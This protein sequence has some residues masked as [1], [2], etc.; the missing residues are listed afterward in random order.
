MSL[1]Q[2]DVK[3]RYFFLQWVLAF[4]T[5]YKLAIAG[6]LVALLMTSTITLSLGQGIRVMIDQGFT[7]SQSDLNQAV[8]IFLLAV[9]FLAAATC[10]RFF[11]VSWIGERVVTDIRR[12]V[13]DHLIDLHPAYFE[14][15]LSSEIQSRLTTDTTLIQTVIGSSVSIALRNILMFFGGIIWLFITNVKLTLIVMASVPLV[16]IPI[17]V[18]GRRVRKL[19]RTSQD[20]VADVGSYIAETLSN[21]K[22]VQAHNHQQLD[23]E[24]FSFFAE[25]AFAASILR[26]KSRAF[27]ILFVIV[28]VL[29]AVAVMLWV[30]GQDV[31]Q[32]KITGG[33]L[34]AFVFYAIIV[35]SAVNAIGEVIGELQRAAGAAERIFELL[36]SENELIE[37]PKD[38]KHADNYAIHVENIEFAYPTRPTHLAL[39]QLSLEVCDGESVA[40][41]GP[42]GGG[43]STLFDLLLRFYDPQ[44]GSLKIGDVDIRGLRLDSLREMI[45]VVRQDAELFNG[46]FWYNIRYGCP[47]ATDDQVIAA[48]KAA[49]AHE[50]IE[51]MPAGYETVIGEAGKQLSGGQKQ[52]VAIAR[53]ILQNPKI[54]L[55][56]EATSA[57]DAESEYQV[58]EA[59]D[60]LMQGRTSIVIAHRLATVKNVDR[61]AVLAEGKIQEI[62]SHE[63]LLASNPLYARLAKL[64]FL[65]KAG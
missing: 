51:K 17:V 34:G 14:V 43:K 24:R 5:P 46:D 7:S 33:E 57:L 4:L 18:Y 65:E 15:N 3:N 40:L 11:L 23:R 10:F 28:L 47:T 32:G 60:K 19:S 36:S 25:E 12:T 37:P 26:V 22:T 20:K 42:S 35:G 41:V 62:G 59:L 64:Q 55:L 61:I 8:G 27:M 52:R 53:A 9:G 56:D 63:S 21:I 30:G 2:E 54:L 16:I 13:F 48:A 49:N 31:M 29:T 58:Q 44:K 45:A 6:A 1:E 39:D 50:F 38:Q